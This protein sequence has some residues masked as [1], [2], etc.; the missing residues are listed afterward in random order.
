MKTGEVT[1]SMRY[2]QEEDPVSRIRGA[3]HGGHETDDERD[4]GRTGGWRRL[5]GWVDKKV[6]G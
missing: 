6:S 1:T 2:V 5:H 3:Q 4:V